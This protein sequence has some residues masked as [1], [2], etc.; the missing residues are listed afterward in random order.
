MRRGAARCAAAPGKGFGP[1]S[2]SLAEGSWGEVRR[3]VGEA[4]RSGDDA[5]HS[6]V[7]YGT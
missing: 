5:L 4:K 1:F 3:D 2:F 7:I 6:E